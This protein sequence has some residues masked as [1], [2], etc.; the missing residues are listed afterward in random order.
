[1]TGAPRARSPLL[2]AWRSY[3]DGRTHYV[4]ASNGDEELYDL[5]DDAEE[6]RNLAGEQGARLD[7]AR[8]HLDTVHPSR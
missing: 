7:R 5:G 8:T 1:V 4:R 3:T 6:E 2:L